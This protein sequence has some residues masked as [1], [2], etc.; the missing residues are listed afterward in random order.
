M[1]ELLLDRFWGINCRAT[2]SAVMS[3]H[4]AKIVGSCAKTGNIGH[5]S[6]IVC[7]SIRFCDKS[8][9]DIHKVL[10][11]IHPILPE[12]LLDVSRISCTSTHLRA[13]LSTRG[14]WS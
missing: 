2:S 9:T 11:L 12:P 4:T 8:A 3:D 5:I 14:L 6:N 7:N 1:S 10:N 13:G